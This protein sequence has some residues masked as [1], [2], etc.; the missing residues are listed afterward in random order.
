MK[1]TEGFYRAFWVQAFEPGLK[2]PE[3]ID[4]LLLDADNANMNAILA[5]VSR[6]HDAYYSSDVLPFTEDPAIPSGFDPLGY[7][8]EQAK[9]REIEVHPLW[10]EVYNGP[11]EHP[12]HIYHAHGP[13][14]SD[15][16]TWV[17]YG[18]DGNPNEAMPYLDVGHPDF[19][20]HIVEMVTDVANHYDLDGVHL[21]LYLIT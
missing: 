5:Q 2:T 18:Y 20:T 11:P 6:R 14:A 16:D 4:Q 3:E 17:T 7:L 15:Q 1:Q 13:D 10:H 9:E 21:D 19:Q 12:D 8:V